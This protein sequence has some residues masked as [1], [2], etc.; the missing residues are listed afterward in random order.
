M[1]VQRAHLISAD[2]KWCLAGQGR[3]GLRGWV[4]W[5]LPRV[6]L[7][8][9]TFELQCRDC[10]FIHPPFIERLLFAKPPWSLWD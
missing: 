1:G 4:S 8:T 7:L 6:P 5:F 9:L 2:R 10:S 3:A